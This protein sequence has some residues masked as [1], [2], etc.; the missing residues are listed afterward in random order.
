MNK[1]LR[2]YSVAVPPWII[3]GAF[4]ILAPIFLFWTMQ[5]IREQKESATLLLLEKGAALIRSFEA[6][7]RTGM[8]G[9]M[10]IR[11]SGFQLQRLLVETAQQPD[12]EYILVTDTEGKI[13]AHSDSSSIGETYGRDLDLEKLSLTEKAQWRRVSHADG[14]DTFEVFR[15][16]NPTQPYR[17]GVHGRVPPGFYSSDQPHLQQW[18]TERKLVIF[19][20]LDMSTVGEAAKR[21]IRQRVLTAL[22]LLLIGFAGIVLLFLGQAYRSARSSLTRIRAFSEKVVESM[23]IGLLTLNGAGEIVSINQAAEKTLRISPSN[24]AGRNATGVL[25]R[26]LLALVENPGTRI[27]GKELEC[28]LE[29]GTVVP[30]DVS[31]STLEDEEGKLPGHIILFRDLTEVQNLKREIETGKRLASLGR[32]AAGVA[33]EIRNPLSSIKGFAT[34]FQERYRDIPEDRGTAE[35]MVKEVDR[36]NRVISQLLEFARPVTI[37]KRPSSPQ[38]LIQHSLKMIR[39]QASAKE[40]RIGSNLPGEIADVPMDTDKVNQV[41]L[42]LYLNSLEAMDKGGTLSVDLRRAAGRPG[43]EISVSDTGSGIRKEDLPQIF[44]PYFTTRPSGTGLGLAIVH[45]IVE[46]HHGEVRVDSE[47]GRGTAVTIYLPEV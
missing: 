44:E 8:M 28:P 43:I 29:D 32:L 15:R 12:I 34:Y 24:A 23:P 1:T 25:P 7:T 40:I 9:M 46:S 47:P 33:H 20:G 14:T 37:R 42:N 17:R 2:K 6:G 13:L 38:A 18:A 19:L 36:L 16:F 27:V 39:Q 4:I 45:N 10:G 22:V 3:L 11:G 21:D 41:L 31:V 35:I 26:P 5:N 30:L